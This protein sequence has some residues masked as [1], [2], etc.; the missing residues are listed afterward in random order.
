MC[1]KARYRCGEGP[2]GQLRAARCRRRDVLR[3]ETRRPAGACRR[4]KRRRSPRTSTSR[5]TTYYHASMPS[6]APKPTAVVG[7]RSPR[8]AGKAWARFSPASALATRMATCAST[9]CATHRRRAR[10]A[11]F[12]GKATRST[13]STTRARHAQGS[14]KPC[15]QQSS[16]S[17]RGD[18]VALLVYKF[19]G[20][21]PRMC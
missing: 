5:Y 20:S 13:R 7:T 19:F 16:P 3:R 17:P 1:R 10:C 4:R 9:S 8:R 2:V 18:H 15:S 11:Q 21:T 12:V 6:S 14:R